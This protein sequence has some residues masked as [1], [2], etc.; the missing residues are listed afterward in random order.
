MNH[1]QLKAFHAVAESGGFSNA[2]KILGLTQPAVTLQVQALE[3]SYNTKLFKRRGRK[4][5]ITASGKLL[6]NLSKRI[7]SL[8]DEAHTLLSSLGS[9]EVGLLKI[10]ATSSLRSL[11]ILSAFQ[12]QYPGIDFSFTTVSTETID[13]EVLDFRAD[14]AIHHIPTEDKRLFC[15]KIEEA[16]LKLAVSKKH[17]WST[18]KV[19]KLDEITDQMI[20]FPFDLETAREIRG[21]WS[22]LIRYEEE[23]ILSLQNKEI[24]REAVA[25]DLG[26]AFFTEKDIHWDK[27]IHAIDIRDKRL[28]EA[29]YIT[30]LAEE[31]SSHLISS[32]VETATQLSESR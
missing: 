15:L 9:L 2:A 21:H 28:K 26:I 12:A 30:C 22:K 17:P 7:F 3:Q 31:R 27:R 6:L 11:S 20:I 1:V 14:I 25:N 29:T 19:M 18:K 5:E 10:V 4:T 24:G 16:P 23:Q 32:F 13:E 8:E